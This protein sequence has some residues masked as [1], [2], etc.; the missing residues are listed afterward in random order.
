MSNHIHP[1]PPVVNTAPQ[2]LSVSCGAL[3]A[4]TCL[5]PVP[6]VPGPS[7]PPADPRTEKGAS[8][9]PA[10]GQSARCSVK[11]CVFP[12][13]LQ[14]GRVCRYHE[15]LHSSVEAGLFESQQPTLLLSLQAPFGIPDEEPDDSRQRDRKRQATEREEFLLDEAA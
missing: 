7:T 5:A 6:A 8:A 13:P 10:P 14:G 4:Q 1:L 9:P 15:L 3:A 2:P 12:A 11:G